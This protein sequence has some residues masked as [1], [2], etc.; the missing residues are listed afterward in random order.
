MPG[1]NGSKVPPTK[2]IQCFHSHP[3]FLVVS[4]SVGRG[5]R[6]L[7]AQWGGGFALA[8]SLSLWVGGP[9][10]WPIVRGMDVIASGFPLQLRACGPGLSI[11]GQ[12]TK[13][14]DIVWVGVRQPLLSFIWLWPGGNEGL[15]LCYPRIWNGVL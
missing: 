3:G 6:Q 8:C 15:G 14:S 5:Q 1:K 10:I 11:L 4:G 13:T 12:V 2:G 9:V 7:E